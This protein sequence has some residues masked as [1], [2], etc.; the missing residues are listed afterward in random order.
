MAFSPD[1]GKL[2][3]AQSDNIVFVYKLGV[4]WHDKK[5]HHHAVTRLETYIGL[6]HKKNAHSN[7][8]FPQSICNKFAQG[9]AVTSLTWPS[10]VSLSF[11]PTHAP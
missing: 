6:S 9:S 8:V 2:A 3:V 4:D 10:R 11:L 1:S 7:I 5:V